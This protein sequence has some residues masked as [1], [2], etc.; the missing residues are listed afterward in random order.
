MRVEGGG[1][2]YPRRRGLMWA[3]STVAVLCA[4]VVPML[5]AAP[6][7]GEVRKANPFAPRGSANLE[8]DEAALA[9]LGWS[10]AVRS[11]E[12][13]GPGQARLS[14]EIREGSLVELAGESG[15]AGDVLSAR[16]GTLG[17]AVLAAGERRVV[18][19]N[20]SISKQ[21]DGSWQVLDGLDDAAQA[22]FDLGS[23][24]VDAPRWAEAFRLAGELVVAPSLAERMGTPQ[25]A[26]KV[27]GR[28]V[29]MAER[30]PLEPALTD[31]AVALTTTPLDETGGTAVVIG[32]DVIV[33]D[34]YQVSNYG[35]SGGISAF[36]VGTI[37]CN[38]GDV[39]LNWFSYNNQHP[40]IGQ[41]LYRLKNNRFE[42]IG[43]SW[44]K[45]G[46]Y[47]L[48]D[49]L[50]HSNCQPTDGT[51]L[52][53]H[54]ADPYSSSL[55]GTQ[56]NLGPKYQV[57]AHTG[58]YPYPPAGPPYSGNIARRLQVKNSD[59]DPALDG[60]GLYF[61]EG[62]YVTPDDAA[63][64]NQNNNASYRRALVGGGGSSWSLTLTSS[65]QRQQAAIRAW[66][67]N[68]P[69]NVVETDVQ[70]PGEGLFIVSARVT[71]LQNG[72][73]HYEYAVQNLNSHRSARAFSVPIDP[74]GK[75]I[76]IGFHD[77]AY[78]S[79]EPYFMTDWPATVS[80][81][82]IRW[83]TDEYNTNQSANALR[84]GT[85]Y[86][87]RFDANRPPQSSEITLTLFRPGTPAEAA[88]ASIGPVTNANDCNGNTIPDSQDIANGT[89]QDCDGDLI[90]DEC[91]VYGLAATRVAA[92][93][94]RPVYVTA[95]PGDLNRLFMVEQSGRIRILTGG[96]VL[97]TAFLDLS[98]QINSDG[99]RG[100]LSVA[101]DPN[102]ASNGYFYVNYTDLSSNTVIARYSVSGDPNVANS[103]SEVV[104]KTIVQDTANHK[105][106]QL[107]FGPDGF[108]YVGMGDGG[109]AFDP[110]NRAQDSSTLLGKMLR[111]DVNS[112][113]DYIPAAN[114]YVGPS[115]PLDEIW[116]MGFRNPWRF[117]FDRERGDL[118]IGDVGQNSL[119]EIDFQPAS[120]V[121]AENYGWRCME[122]SSC[123]GLSGCTCNSPTLTLPIVEYPHVSGDCS[124]TGG[125]V[126]RGC[127]M[128]NWQ[129]TYFYADFCSDRIRS[130]RYSGGS[131]LDHVDRTAEMIPAEGLITSI[132]SFGEDAAGELYIVSHDGDVYK[133]VP[134]SGS[135]PVCGN[136][137]VEQSEECDDG[138]TTPGDGCDDFCQVENPPANDLCANALPVGNGVYTF[139]SAE[140]TTD[141]PNES[142]VCQ[143]ATL[144]LGSDVWFCYNP[145]CTGTAT[146]SLCESSYDTMLA[147]YAGC[148]CP[149]GPAALACNDDACGTQS[150]LN[151]AVSACDPVLIRIGGYNA[152]R[153][154]GTLE[155]NCQPD[156]IV[157]DCDGNGVED[158][159]DIACGTHTDND[160]NS[161][162]DICQVT[163]NYLR[164]GRLYDRWWLEIAVSE[165]VT[166]HPLW[167]YRP[168]TQ[169]N[170][171][172]GSATWRCTECHGWDYKGVGGEYGSGPHR[173]GI[174]GVLGTTL[175]V[176]ALAD[177]LREPPSNGGGPGVP[178]GHDFGSVLSEQDID[179]LVAFTLA[180]AI[181]TA[182]YLS[183]ST[184][185]FVGDPVTGQA[186]Y[187]SGGTV[188]NCIT[189]H[190]AN[191]AAINFGTPQEPEF[192][193]TAAVYEPSHFL[194][195]TRMGFPGTPMIGWI[196]NGG[197]NQG[198]ADIGRYA[199]TSFPPDCLNDGQCNDG[200]DCT[201]DSCN[202]AGR[203]VFT[204]N[205]SLCPDDGVFCNGLEICDAQTGC[206]GAGN[207]C[208]VP[209][210][211]EEAADGCGCATPTVIA[212][213]PRY[214]A[215][216]LQPTDALAPTRLLVTPNCPLGVGKYV[217][218]PSGP[219]NVAGLVDDPDNAAMRSPAQ[220]GGTVFVTGMGIAPTVEYQVQADCGMPSS[221]VVTPPATATMNR[222]GDLVGWIPTGGYTD[223]DGDVT[224]I[225]ISALVD[226]FKHKIGAPP[227]YA[228]DLFGC[229]PNQLI[230]AID[231]VGVVDA[232]KGF[233]YGASLCP[234]PCW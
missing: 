6:I 117:S 54:C 74:T 80:N 196:A 214:L 168:D 13:Q 23:L 160:S 58:S 113:P 135:G 192:L 83:S 207:P 42:H 103:G 89:S 45:H 53:V 141:G 65:T 182:P 93:L 194:H 60:G 110:F 193:G 211:C 156:P 200:M 9:E 115:L 39:W 124:V 201:D 170:S 140:A 163:G 37:S 129:G 107:Q 36:A 204:P 82:M 121:G 32:P 96:A 98:A 133:I 152:A 179:D 52:G 15:G 102:F 105:G 228:L 146:I 225:D 67:D 138:N 111:L 49:N 157:A 123:T 126:Y 199:Q 63:S 184:K 118:Y 210:F 229:T 72:Y 147:A 176:P 120:S 131:V 189:C 209:G 174:G 104:L 51:H 66:K 132:S 203:C 180:G 59:L 25:A 208:L 94:D 181:N 11:V 216:T 79:G 153:G 100:L 95:P 128:P 144:P 26:G 233:E 155:L 21:T 134:G 217:G 195:R 69:T 130:F 4:A 101:F 173:T 127:A 71:D 62:Q 171:S 177:L 197:T 48:S 224:A 81:G 158:S 3:G 218:P 47:A 231:V 43:Q 35:S 61:V 50:C 183:P 55:N 99:E 84:W 41:S 136:T 154:L 166:D 2:M 226:G 16:L 46:F 125:Y 162:P 76:N 34:L 97:A 87:F 186:H 31:A 191:G 112:P 190:G 1:L 68:D 30:T 27:V 221:P 219:Y 167:A 151:I 5:G 164:G 40:V 172:A 18:I 78:H 188:S 17:G 73:W 227:L 22:V 64:G 8:F 90:P 122:G 12:A 215:I 106:G 86:N 109:G 92:G 230:D 108:L 114:P 161:V 29:V 20:L 202:A 44:L 119:E 198:A 56:Y 159:A 116:A 206:V 24:T 150:E 70:V 232:F 220:W 178:D 139:N 175:T 77:V 223:A 7:Q 213:G 91:E 165:P 185:L 38:I 14:S 75:I 145:P 57:D 137:I 187:T 212:A 10:A 19:G 149:S 33:G 234:G 148:S 143:S 85:L 88:A 28:V 205:H 222:W 142:G 169:S